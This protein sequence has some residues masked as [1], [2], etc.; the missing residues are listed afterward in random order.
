MELAKIDFEQIIL[1]SR[2][3]GYPLRVS[4]YLII[5]IFISYLIF[6]SFLIKINV[7]LYLACI[8][9]LK[10]RESGGSMTPTTSKMDLLM[11]ITDVAQPFSIAVKK[12]YLRCFTDPRSTSVS[13]IYFCCKYAL[14]K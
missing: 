8:K 14:G 5:L 12:F 2:V 4:S 13:S 6:I 1:M 9:L 10:I 11:T 7:N 3:S